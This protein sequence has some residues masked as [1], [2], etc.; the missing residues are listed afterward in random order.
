MGLGGPDLLAVDAPAVGGLLRPRADR[1][2]VGARIGLAHA[3][4]EIAFAARDGGDV[5]PA[6]LFR[7]ELQQ[8]GAA[9][10]VGHPMGG[11]GG[12][13]GQH[14]LQHHV[15]L[16]KTFPAT[17]VFLGP[18][19]ADPATGPHGL[20]KFRVGPGPGFGALDAWI[21]LKMIGDEG[22]DLGAKGLG[23]GR[24][25]A[26]RETNV[27]QDLNPNSLGSDCIQSF[28]NATGWFT[29]RP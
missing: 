29:T 24:Q 8:Q 6:L 9:L 13:G 20:G 10:P 2:Q 23:L 19:H 16:Q 21:A 17:A 25:K 4:A 14:F 27:L 15:A 22:A 12:T 7:A 18:G 28:Y 3:D 5:F 1:G 26:R 11:N